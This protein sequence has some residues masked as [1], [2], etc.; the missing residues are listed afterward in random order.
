MR[1]LNYA[2]N[3]EQFKRIKQDIVPVI[4][5]EHQ[6][7]LIMK[8]FSGK[9]LT[10]SEKTEFS[11]TISKRIK[12][13]KKIAQKDDIL[14]Y[15]KEKMIPERIEKAKKIIKKLNRKFKSKQIVISGSFLYKKHYNDIDIFVI[16]KYKKEDYKLGEFHINYLTSTDSLFFFS[17]SKLCVSNNKI[18][19]ELT[20]EPELDKYISLFQEVSNDIFSKRNFKHSLKEFLLYSGFIA[21][22]D[23]PDS[24]DLSRKYELMLNKNMFKIVKNIF[25]NSVI[26]GNFGYTSKNDFAHMKNLYKQA[27][28]DNKK[29]ASY[30]LEMAEAFGEV[31]GFG[32]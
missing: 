14:I 10:N 29:H 2:V 17:L 27:A 28:K 3:P 11:R 23:L 18:E 12:A 7:Q 15:N 32:V 22:E 26:L 6:F 16:T 8:K 1:K 5:T 30:Y 20:E 25:V 9:P 19:C 24:K 31:I 13:I 21:G 4:F